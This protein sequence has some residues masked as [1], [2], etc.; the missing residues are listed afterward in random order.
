VQKEFIKNIF[1]LLFI[2]VLIK[3]FYII[4]I[5][6][7]VQNRVGDSEY[8]IYF[9]IFD[10]CFLFQVILDLGIQNYNSKHV[11]ENRETVS[12]HF[13]HIIG[14]KI[15]LL[16]GFFLAMFVAASILGYP[17]YY[18]S[19]IGL[20]GLI[21]TFQT[22]YLYLRSHFSA[23]GHFRID[24]WLS[25][26]DKILMIVFVGFLL[27]G[28]GDISILKFMY[29]QIAALVLAVIVA[30]F[31]LQKKFS[32][33]VKFSPDRWKSILKNSLPFALVFIL[34]TLYTRMDGVMLERLIDAQ[35]A[36]YYAKGFRLM[37]AANM[38][39]YL[40]AMLL[41]PMYARLL[42][43]KKTIDILLSTAAQIQFCITSIITIA[44]WFYAQDILDVIYVNVNEQI[45]QSFRLLMI[46]FWTIAMSYIYGSLIIASGELRALNFIFV[47]G[48][49]LNW[50]LN[51]ILIPTYMAVGAAIATL[52]TQIFV[53]L[54]QYIIVQKRFNIKFNMIIALKAIGL[55]GMY[56]ATAYILYEYV[57]LYCLLELSIFV[58]FSMI[59]SFFTG[60]LRFNSSILTLES[61]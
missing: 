8:G 13:S 3:P 54:G 48:I 35:S 9:A 30:L 46:S 17:S 27:Y 7:Q 26:V 61:N 34:M 56:F 32:V 2:N 53:F 57:K 28:I 59:I 40:F 19:L 51:L 10:F 18:Y 24:T 15:V 20:M 47:A 31:L 22:F 52:I 42:H 38:I 14:L 21:M 1:F 58:I 16:I 11:S 33:S 37:D 60:F 36:G 4:G 50:T 23:L 44:C 6:A 45:V 39:G 25:I 55:L 5:D 49:I 29:A 43:E 41:L 12:E